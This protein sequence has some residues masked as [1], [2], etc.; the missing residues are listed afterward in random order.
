MVEDKKPADDDKVDAAGNM[1]TVE[2]K[3]EAKPDAEPVAPVAPVVAETP[4]EEKGESAELA[5]LKAQV[6]KLAA[7]ITTLVA[8]DKAVHAELPEEAEDEDSDKKAEMVNAISE[9]ADSA[10]SGVKVI[11]P[12]D[13]KNLSSS[14]YVRRTIKFNKELIDPKYHFL[15]DKVDAS[16]LSIA[17][18]AI[19]NMKVNV[20]KKSAE[21]YSSASKNKSGTYIPT[22][23]GM[24][25]DAN[26]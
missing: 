2:P 26:F 8:S 21:L 16:N 14:D 18:D 24:E 17:H 15:A 9:M 20:E 11:K 25:V 23:N 13:S 19:G 22:R 4:A 7:V 12:V 5:A 10:H 1:A 3:P 6:E